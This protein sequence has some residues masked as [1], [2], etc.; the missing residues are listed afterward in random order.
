[1]GLLLT[2]AHWTSVGVHRL[3]FFWDL[4]KV[5][6]GGGAAADGICSSSVCRCTRRSECRR[7]EEKNG[8]LWS[9][10]QQCVKIVSF[11]P[12]NLSCKKTQK[13]QALL[14]F[15]LI[16]AHSLPL[17]LPTSFCLP[18]LRG[19]QPHYLHITP[20]CRAWVINSFHCESGNRAPGLPT[21]YWSIQKTPS[22][23]IITD[24]VDCAHSR[25]MESL[26]YVFSLSSCFFFLPFLPDY[27]S[28]PPFLTHSCIFI[29]LSPFSDSQSISSLLKGNRSSAVS[30]QMHW[31]V[32]MIH[33]AEMLVLWYYKMQQNCS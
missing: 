27:F 7:A 33:Q 11:Y 1:M 15:S 23:L 5:L 6:R 28:V 31:A 26:S 17:F 18:L 8:W 22:W 24:L 10:R 9:P 25:K 2:A 20:T 21:P 4:V 13:V 19:T 32:W 16:H 29:N 3:L 14:L 12:P 30:L